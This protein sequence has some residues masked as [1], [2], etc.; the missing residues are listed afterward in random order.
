VGVGDHLRLAQRHCVRDG[1]RVTGQRPLRIAQKKESSAAVGEAA[2]PGVVAAKGQGLR[3]V[4]V[5]L[6]E[7]ERALHVITDRVQIAAEYRR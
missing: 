3:S 4:P 6:V 1:L 7:G 2:L 5:H